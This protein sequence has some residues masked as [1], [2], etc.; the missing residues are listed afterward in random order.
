MT[1]HRRKF[2]D[3]TARAAGGNRHADNPRK[4]HHFDSKTIGIPVIADILAS[5]QG[6]V[7]HYPAPC[8]TAADVAP[9]N[10]HWVFGGASERISSRRNE[11]RDIL[12]SVEKQW[13][14]NPDGLAIGKTALAE[15]RTDEAL[16]DFA[17]MAAL[18]AIPQRSFINGRSGNFYYCGQERFRVR[19]IRKTGTIWIDRRTA[20][21]SWDY[22]H[23]NKDAFSTIIKI[24]PLLR[25]LSPQDPTDFKRIL[26]Y[27]VLLAKATGRNVAT[28]ISG[29]ARIYGR[30]AFLALAAKHPALKDQTRVM[31]AVMAL[32]AKGDIS[33]NFSIFVQKTLA[34]A[35]LP[36]ECQRQ[37]RRTLGIF[38]DE[39]WDLLNAGHFGWNDFVKWQRTV[40]SRLADNNAAAEFRAIWRV[41]EFCLTR[42]AGKWRWRGWH[43]LP[44]GDC[45]KDAGSAKR[46]ASIAQTCKTT[47]WRILRLGQVIGFFEM[48]GIAICL[49]AGLWGKALILKMTAVQ[50]DSDLLRWLSPAVRRCLSPPRQGYLFTAA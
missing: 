36:I 27:F 32:A 49:S 21:T 39:V 38:R 44:R 24:H 16:M 45:R 3:G 47:A 40:I 11:V 42:E 33:K 18:D 9:S 4:S 20:G 22:R 10:A 41:W 5:G 50:T 28:K 1:S 13:S 17:L 31:F 25:G 34:A 37:V 2:G 30:R 35:A 14:A 19:K 8:K 6:L 15:L 26:L 29:Q 46:L 12:L 48:S 43:T 23:F 7:N